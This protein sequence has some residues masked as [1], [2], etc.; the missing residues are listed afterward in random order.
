MPPLPRWALQSTKLGPTSRH[1]SQCCGTIGPGGTPLQA[2][3]Q[4]LQVPRHG[5]TALCPVTSSTN[6]GA[7]T[8]ILRQFSTTITLQADKALGQITVDHLTMS[9]VSH[10]FCP[11]KKDFSGKHP[12]AVV[13]EYEGTRGARHVGIN[14][15]MDLTNGSYEH[16]MGHLPYLRV[17]ITGGATTIGP[18]A[19]HPSAICQNLR[20]GGG[21]AGGWRGGGG[22]WQLGRGGRSQGG[23]GTCDPLLPHAYLKGGCVSGGMGIEVCVR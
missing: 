7:G 14:V 13:L 5:S 22:N 15:G 4:M 6:R 8:Q 3:I 10:G 20:G 1:L 2:I 9:V 17:Q 19:T 12:C 21:S 18:D 16:T 11:T 23:G